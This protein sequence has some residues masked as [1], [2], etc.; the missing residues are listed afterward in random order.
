[1]EKK[2][3]IEFKKYRGESTVVSSRLPLEVV[4]NIDNIAEKTGRNRN[5]IIL[6]CLEFA[7]ENIVVKERKEVQ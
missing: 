1:M 6:M 7:L 5:E 2:L 3:E 4:K